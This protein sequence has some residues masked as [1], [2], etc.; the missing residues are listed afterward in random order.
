MS[1]DLTWVIDFRNSPE[2]FICDQ[3]LSKDWCKIN[4]IEELIEGEFSEE[5]VIEYFNSYTY[6]EQLKDFW[7]NSVVIN[8]KRL[9]IVYLADDEKINNAS[10]FSY[11]LKS[12]IERFFNQIGLLDSSAINCYLLS[13]WDNAWSKEEELSKINNLYALNLFQNIPD[14]KKRPFDFVLIFKDINSGLEQFE[15]R[16]RKSNADYFNTKDT[17]LISHISNKNNELLRRL[18]ISRWCLSFGAS[19]IYFNAQELY[20]KSAKELGDLLV[21]ELIQKESEPWNVQFDQPIDEKIKPLEFKSVFDSI[22]Y[23]QLD[24]QSIEGK[25]NFYK[26]DFSPIWDWFALG[27]LDMFFNESL[28]QLLKKLK[29]G[30][31]EYLFNEYNKMR[32]EVE[33]N[34]EKLSNFRAGGI[35]TPEIIFGSY[36]KKK[37]FSFQSY[38]KGLLELIAIIEKRKLE[39]KDAFNKRYLDPELPYAPCSMNPRVRE[40][41]NEFVKEYNSK[42]DLLLNKVVEDQTLKIKQKA[43]NIA[44]PASLLFKTTILSTIIVLF[45]FIPLNSFLSDNIWVF[46]SVL[47]L[48]FI[49]PF[50]L[51][52]SKFRKNADQL[53]SLC[54]EFEALSKYYA[55][56]KLTENIFRSIES[57]YEE[58]LNNCKSELKQLENKFEE[59]QSFLNLK[60]EKDTTIVNSLSVRSA[61]G[62]AERIPPIKISLNGEFFETKDLKNDTLNLF[63]YFK[64]TVNTDEISLNSLVTSKFDYLKNLII[65]QL[66]DSPDNISSA[67]DL[68]FPKLGV[69]IKKD[70]RELLMNLLPPYNNGQENLDNISSEILLESYRKSE[71]DKV[72]ELFG[73]FK[74]Q[75]IRYKNESSAFLSYGSISALTINQPNSNVYDLFSSSLGGNKVSFIQHSENYYKSNNEQFKNILQKIIK[76]TIISTNTETTEN[77]E[78]IFQTIFKGFDLNLDENGWQTFITDYDSISN[79]FVKEFR[80]LFRSEFEKVLSEYLNSKV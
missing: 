74:P 18:D 55:T 60:I 57:L 59:A 36:F 25:T 73:D 71:D 39:N 23:K 7:N 50:I 49:T 61:T 33:L 38:R 9:N 58:Y 19:H 14:I 47:T 64:Q 26:H 29:V 43:E 44:H 27:K 69:N 3:I 31:V 75:I 8:P 68:L 52:W 17:A 53:N 34:F 41:Y 37:P 28:S 21:Q 77:R 15:F 32:N 12:D 13:Y 2:K 56:R 35:E 5:K 78:Q 20:S 10:I 24:N 1:N 79:P 30:K 65:K 54:N 46:Y 4:K 80:Q 62:I 70:D 51:M 40:K 66:K 42:D 48:F 72:L 67:S 6:R 76:E 45:T 63:N 16:N 11:Q 22:K